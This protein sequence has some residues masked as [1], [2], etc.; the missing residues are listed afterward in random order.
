MKRL[1]S[2]KSGF[3]V[4]E[5]VM[6]F[7]IFSI[8]AGMILA[9]L[10]LTVEQRKANNDFAQEL[11]AQTQTLVQ[12]DKE[13]KSAAYADGQITLTANGT[14]IA[15]I[16]YATAGVTAGN[17]A[18]GIN[19]FIGEYN[20]VKGAELTNDSF[21]GNGKAV[22]K[23]VDSRIYGS[24][25][26]KEIR[27]YEIKRDT[28]Y[29]G[30]GVK[31]LIECSAGN[32]KK[33]TDAGTESD[34]NAF[35]NELTPYRQYILFFPNQNIK[36]AGYVEGFSHRNAKTVSA[37]LTQNK[38]SVNNVG[39][40]SV[41]ISIP[42]GAGSDEDDFWSYLHTKLY[43]VFENDPGILPA[44]TDSTA[45]LSSTDKKK[46]FGYFGDNVEMESTGAY[47]YFTSGTADTVVNSGKEKKDCIRCDNIYGVMKSSEEVNP[48]PDD[49]T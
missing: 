18:D 14:D 16:N 37:P 22:N 38:Y 48:E 40:S 4:V 30:V 8:M 42:K 20:D 3:T 32:V 1:F 49:E 27:I 45:S 25:G 12:K 28:S 17:T 41:L 29:T 36:E 13:K 33:M 7:L 15:S 35:S 44:G 31:Y 39:K 23:R 2:K 11:D 47:A 26:F 34:E 21:D 6:A 9:V 19:Y 24:T 5:I 10:R 43:I 46:A